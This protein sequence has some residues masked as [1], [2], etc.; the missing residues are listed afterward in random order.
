MTIFEPIVIKSTFYEKNYQNHDDLKCLINQV[1]TQGVFGICNFLQVLKIF[2][3]TQQETI[4]E[5]H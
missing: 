5:T 1:V 3:F 2:R 4:I